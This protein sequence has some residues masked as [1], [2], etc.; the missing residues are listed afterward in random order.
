MNGLVHALR[1]HRG[2]R[3]EA[4]GVSCLEHLYRLAMRCPC[5]SDAHEKC[6]GDKSD[7]ET[8]EHGAITP[9]NSNRHNQQKGSNSPEDDRST[10]Q[11]PGHRE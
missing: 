1:N 5:R 3:D 9:A 11:E 4:T 2:R 7:H 10:R 8:G 6:G